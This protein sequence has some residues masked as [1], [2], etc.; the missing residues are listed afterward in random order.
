MTRALLPKCCPHSPSPVVGVVLRRRHAGN[1]LAT[2]SSVAAGAAL[3]LAAAALWD[4]LK[5]AVSFGAMLRHGMALNRL[6]LAHAIDPHSL[7][8]IA[9]IRVSSGIAHNILHANIPNIVW[10]ALCSGALIAAQLIVGLFGWAVVRR[11]TCFSHFV[12]PGRSIP[13]RPHLPSRSRGHSPSSSSAAASFAT[14]I[15]EGILHPHLALLASSSRSS[16]D[17]PH[18]GAPERQARR[19]QGEQRTRRAKAA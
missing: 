12:G 13:I 7:H 2:S 10:L 16:S 18:R 1:T 4:S 17:D 15:L 11:Q 6:T 9:G 3:F 5:D 14:G 19:T 8:G